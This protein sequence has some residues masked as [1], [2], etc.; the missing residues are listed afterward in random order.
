[1]LE[2][3]WQPRRLLLVGARDD[4]RARAEAVRAERRADPGAAVLLR[5]V[6]VHQAELVRLADDVGGVG[7]VHVV[8][9]RPRPDLLLRERAGER[10]QLAL[11]IG[12]RERDSARYTLADRS[13]SLRLGIRLTSQS[14]N[15]TC[16]GGGSQTLP[17]GRVRYGRVRRGRVSRGHDRGLSP[18]V[19]QFAGRRE[20]TLADGRLP[21]R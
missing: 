14:T 9:G 7:H 13:H 19:R 3:R 17:I 20:R 10:A 1:M 8:L 21:S 18:L 6:E 5:N 2:E 4:D 15:R 16:G 12:E 11:L